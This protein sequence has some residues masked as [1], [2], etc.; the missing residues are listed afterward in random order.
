MHID[1]KKLLTILFIITGPIVCFG[2][3]VDIEVAD[4]LDAAY[5]SAHR[6]IVKEAGLRRINVD[7]TIL[8]PSPMGEGDVIKFIQTLPGISTG[9]E[10]SSAIYVRGGNMGNNSITID[11]VPLYGYGHLLGLTTVFSPDIV[12]NM[13]F[14]VGGFDGESG[15]L[16]AS[17]IKIST[18]DGDFLKYH[19]NGS[20]NNFMASSSVSGPIVKDKLTFVLS[21]RISPFG[22]EYQAIK[23]LLKDSPLMFEHFQTSVYDLYGKLSYRISPKITLRG[24]VFN[25]NDRYLYGNSSTS[26]DNMKWSNLVSNLNLEYSINDRWY[27]KS[28]ASYTKFNSRQNQKKI[29]NGVNNELTINSTIYELMA[30]EMV[31]FQITP[32]MDIKFGITGKFSRFNPG[33]SKFYE[34]TSWD[35]GEDIPY[36]NK[37][38]NNFLGTAFLEYEFT[39]QNKYRLMVAGRYNF[40]LKGDDK[41]TPEPL[42]H[43]PEVSVVAS[44]SFAPWLG[45]EATFDYLTQYYHTLEGIPLGWS[46]DLIVP[47]SSKHAPEKAIQ[48]YLGLFSNIGKQHRISIGAFYKE[49]KNLVYFA[50][51]TDFFTSGV[52]NWEDDI[53]I[54]TGTGRG[55]ELLY[56]KSGERL[57]YR[58][59]Y[60]LSESMRNF[61]DMNLGEDFRSKFD[62]P[63]IL[64]ANAT[65]L[66]SDKEGFKFALSTSFALQSGHLETVKSATYPGYLPGWNGEITLDYFSGPNNYRMPT[67]I[68]WDIGANLKFIREKTTHTLNIGIYNTLNRF[69]PFSLYYNAETMQWQMMALFPIMPNFSY[70]IEL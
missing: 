34:G 3:N 25:S 51:A 21:G 47:S 26:I 12:Q 60:T 57:N 13:D 28:I 20:V 32:L 56:E 62:R 50:E 7:E 23:G 45:V 33:S 6:T 14:Y 58:I 64:N 52:A 69:N 43:N 42:I 16:L 31:L 11:G 19:A 61:P 27:F 46:L 9:G 54:G 30:K 38:S 18:I 48:Y 22:L 36:V 35:E 29:L 40:F 15:N 39:R 59:A 65:Y 17:H 44:Y 5:T 66:I 37:Y 67:Y 8:I 1:M 68:R 41:Y 49:M 53:K 10:G 4:T 24:S 70:R 2:Q 63:H 55:I